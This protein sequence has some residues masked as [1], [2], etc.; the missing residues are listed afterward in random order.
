MVGHCPK[1]QHHQKQ[2]I[3][4]I[5]VLFDLLGE[6]EL[7]GS[8]DDNGPHFSVVAVRVDAPILKFPNG[9]LSESCNDRVI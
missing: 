1:P 8:N 2:E 6:V 3:D 4:G 7:V 5:E 9:V